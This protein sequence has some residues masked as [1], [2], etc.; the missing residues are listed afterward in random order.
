MPE[1]KPT[2][3]QEE[4]DLAALGANVIDKESD[5][6]PEESSPGPPAGRKP[7]EQPPQEQEAE[8]ELEPRQRAM[9]AE[10]PGGYQ[11]RRMAAARGEE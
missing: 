1:V 2:P 3:T 11:T 7:P 6:S 4:N 10:R 8:Q 5:G 9:Q